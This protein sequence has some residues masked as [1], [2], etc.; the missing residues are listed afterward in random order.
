MLKKFKASKQNR[1]FFKNKIGR[2]NNSPKSLKLIKMVEKRKTQ[3]RSVTLLKE[4]SAKWASTEGRCSIERSNIEQKFQE[5]N[6][7][8]FTLRE[9]Y[10]EEGVIEK[11]D[12]NK[13]TVP[14]YIKDWALEFARKCFWNTPPDYF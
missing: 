11:L 6:F 12:N 9:I 8:S 1:K 10:L 7:R 13:A 2:K 14:R 5:F 3:S 4:F